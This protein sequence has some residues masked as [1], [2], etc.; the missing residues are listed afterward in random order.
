MVMGAHCWYHSVDPTG[1][2]LI[3]N[4]KRFEL[5]PK[6]QVDQAKPNTGLVNV[7][8]RTPPTYPQFESAV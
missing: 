4:C 5:M 8:R 6:A 2:R 3:W 1:L 7:T